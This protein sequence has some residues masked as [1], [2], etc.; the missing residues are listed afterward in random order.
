MEQL[1]AEAD[2]SLEIDESEDWPEED[3]AEWMQYE[4]DKK[5]AAEEQQR[6]NWAQEK[7]PVEDDVA[8]KSITLTG[9]AAWKVRLQDG[10]TVS[11]RGGGNSLAPLIKSGEC[12]TYAPVRK[13]E[14]VK[15]RDVGIHRSPEP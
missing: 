1:V 10:E 4:A 14:D 6:A 15:V 12:C 9:N 5:A 7:A 13:H 2:T 3:G 8:T 11:F